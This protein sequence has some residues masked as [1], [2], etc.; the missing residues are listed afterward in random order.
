MYIHTCACLIEAKGNLLR[1][2]VWVVGSLCCS[3]Q[4]EAQCGLLSPV[5]PLGFPGG[6]DGKASACNVGDPGSI[7]GSGGSS[8][9]GNGNPFQYFS[10]LAWRI[11]WT[12]KTDGLQS[13]GSQ[14]IGHD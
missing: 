12:G 10:I 13:M 1:S 5:P 7:P 9:E 2:L 3:A 6:S 8:G 4:G 11:P 14:R